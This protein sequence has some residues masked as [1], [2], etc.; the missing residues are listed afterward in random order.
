M[1]VEE[2]KGEG[3]DLTRNNNEKRWCWL[4]DP[5]KEKESNLQIKLLNP[6]REEEGGLILLK[7]TQRGAYHGVDEQ[8]GG[9]EGGN[10]DE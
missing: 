4:A 9:W 10:C 7:Q 8:G 1:E 6:G 5:L 2:K 3:F